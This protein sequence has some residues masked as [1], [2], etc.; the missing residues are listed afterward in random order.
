MGL[1]HSNPSVNHLTS[2]HSPLLLESGA[3]QRTGS[4]C[5]SASLCI[6]GLWL[7]LYYRI[8]IIL[9]AF[10][11][12]K[13]YQNVVL[14]VFFFNVIF[15]VIMNLFPLLYFF[16]AFSMRLWEAG[17]WTLVFIMDHSSQITLYGLNVEDGGFQQL[18][19]IVQYILCNTEWVKSREFT[20]G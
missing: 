3:L 14:L 12:P 7:P 6:R 19:S 5:A 17:E 9:P 2:S 8:S 16:T 11:L 15:N 10:C 18:C 4:T 1:P 20:L 13:I